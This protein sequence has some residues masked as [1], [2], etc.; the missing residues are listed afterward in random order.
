MGERTATYPTLHEIMERVDCGKLKGRVYTRDGKWRDVR[1]V[2]E[3]Q[4]TETFC[5]DVVRPFIGAPTTETWPGLQSTEELQTINFDRIRS[6]IQI[7]LDHSCGRQKVRRPSVPC[8]LLHCPTRRLVDAD[9]DQ[10][11]FTLSY[12]WESP[13]AVDQQRLK[14]EDGYFQDPDLPVVIEDAVKA[15]NHL[16]GRYDTSRSG[17]SQVRRESSSSCALVGEYLWIDQICIDQT[18]PEEIQHTMDAMAQIY[19]GALATIV[20]ISEIGQVGIPGFRRPR[21]GHVATGETREYGEPAISSLQRCLAGSTW[22]TRGWTYQEALLSTRCIFFTEEQV[23]YVCQAISCCE[24]GVI[25]NNWSSWQDGFIFRTLGVESIFGGRLDNMD[26]FTRYHA[27]EL[28]Q[29]YYRHVQHFTARELSLQSD[30]LNA[31]RGLASACP[32]RIYWGIPLSESGSSLDHHRY[33]SCNDH[34]GLAHG[35]TWRPA[36]MDSN[37][38]TR[39]VEEDLIRW[40]LERRRLFPSWSWCGWRGP[41]QYDQVEIYSIHSIPV[42]HVEG[43]NGSFAHHFHD[44]SYSSNRGVIP[45]ESIFI[46]L[47]TPIY[48]LR[49]FKSSDRGDSYLCKQKPLS[50]QTLS[51][52]PSAGIVR[53]VFDNPPVSDSESFQLTYGCEGASLCDLMVGESGP[54]VVAILLL[55]WHGNVHSKGCFDN[56]QHYRRVG[57]AYIPR[58]I[59]GT[60]SYKTRT[61]RLG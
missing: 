9:W 1:G 23:F 7:C 17:R 33:N 27:H 10:A 57:I 59:L 31:F 14:D 53:I 43:L 60:L 58:D 47:T 54:W 30:A 61:I 38:S 25:R 16:A 19:E 26:S 15:V 36:P 34:P 29:I 42:F 6:W 4:L 45:E 8:R 21:S 18:D 48:D 51:H 44:R 32:L 13:I 22:N 46:H 12:R 24:A 3:E 41:V 37:A 52:D 39:N 55:E 5:T 11:Y 35:M 40:P 56:W 2:D 49:F 28:R 20:V 50:G